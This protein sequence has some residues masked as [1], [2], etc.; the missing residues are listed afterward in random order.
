MAA[1]VTRPADRRDA[2]GVAEAWLRSR[3]AAGRHIPPPAH[4]D[5]EVRGWVS[6]HLLS[7]CE[8]WIAASEAGEIIGLLA[9]R[10]DWVDQ[11]YVVPEWQR[12]AVGR[13]L[14]EIAKRARP[15]GL[16]LWTFVSNEPARRFYMDQ[17]FVCVQQTDGSENEE[18][19]PDM[20]FVW[21]DSTE[22][23][24]S[25]LELQVGDGG[26]GHRVLDGLS[27]VRHEVS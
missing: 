11:L 6:S 4:S 10:Q 5:D 8:C 18:R 14:L 27:D 15:D 24:M 17:G 25:P 9:L 2:A 26:P 16:Q 19:A 23:P 7:D 22:T 1:F 20:R 12:R 13:T 3:R 21:P